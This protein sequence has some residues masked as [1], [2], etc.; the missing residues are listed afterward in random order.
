MVVVLVE[1]G[2][3]VN[4]ASKDGGT[5]L[6]EAAYYGKTKVAIFIFLFKA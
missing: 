5:P 3:D 6:W 1:N 2:A 4:L